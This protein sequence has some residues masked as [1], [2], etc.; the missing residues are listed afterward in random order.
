MQ[1]VTVFLNDYVARRRTG[2]GFSADD[3]KTVNSCWHED[4]QRLLA[5]QSLQAFRGYTKWSQCKTE[6]FRVLLMRTIDIMDDLTD[7]DRMDANNP[8]ITTFNFLLLGLVNCIEISTGSTLEVLRLNRIS[9]DDML[10]DFSATMDLSFAL[11]SP[12]EPGDEGDPFKIVI[13][14]TK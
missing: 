4:D 2:I 14:N 12:R 6:H 11:P 3:Y 7:E 13:D 5:L 1:Q 8:I 9:K 10:F